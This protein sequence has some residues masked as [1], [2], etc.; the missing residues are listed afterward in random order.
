[1]RFELTK[2]LQRP[3]APGRPLSEELK[4]RHPVV[5]AGV[6][7]AVAATVAEVLTRARLGFELSPVVD[8]LPAPPSRLSV[9][10]L[11][12][13]MVVVLAGGAI[14]VAQRRLRPPP[15]PP[16]APVAQV[17]P[18]LTNTT[19]S[20]APVP[21]A[22]APVAR[23]WYRCT[24]AGTPVEGTA[25]FLT[26]IC[27]EHDCTC[28]IPVPGV[29]LRAPPAPHVPR[30]GDAAL[31]PGAR[32]ESESTPAP[33]GKMIYCVSSWFEKIG[34]TLMPHRSL[35]SGVG[36]PAEVR[37]ECEKERSSCECGESPR[38]AYPTQLPI[39]EATGCKADG[40]SCIN[41]RECCIGQCTTSG[42]CGA[43]LKTCHPGNAACERSADCCSASCMGG[44]CLP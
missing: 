29:V 42:V 37:A 8:A 23:D 32:G 36:T 22:V 11:R 25:A 13:A 28:E 18:A 14:W 7:R 1:M 38:E 4:A 15:P 40:S 3:G 2:V 31:R 34:D 21:A 5:A 39:L 27:S 20:R 43:G 16:R 33:T 6:T 12:L 24:R 10:P 26:G 41:D 17:A 9:D 44:H 35:F 19:A 30:Y